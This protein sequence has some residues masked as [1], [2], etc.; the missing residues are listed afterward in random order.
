[1]IPEKKSSRS[2]REFVAINVTQ[3]AINWLRRNFAQFRAQFA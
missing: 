1:M 2:R 3:R